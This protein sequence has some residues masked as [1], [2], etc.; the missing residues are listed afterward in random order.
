MLAFAMMAA[1]RLHAN[2]FAEATNRSPPKKDALQSSD[3]ASSEIV[4]PLIRWSRQE[5]LRITTR[6]ARKRIRP[7]FIIAWSLWRR[8]HQAKAKRA[9]I[10]MQL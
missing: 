2:A 9:H 8:A 3:E 7:E 4:I 10:K 6:L 5:I 1:I